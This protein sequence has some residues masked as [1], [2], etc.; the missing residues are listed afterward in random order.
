[1]H[2]GQK[3]VSAFQSVLDHRGAA[4]WSLEYPLSHL[5]LG[6]AYVLQNDIAKARTAYQDFFAAWKDADADIPILKEARAEY[7]KLK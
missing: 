7:D 5:Y 6:R 4:S 2:D 3:A 1:M